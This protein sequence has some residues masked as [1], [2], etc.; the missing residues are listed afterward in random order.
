MEIHV[1]DSVESSQRGV[2]SPGPRDVRAETAAPRSSTCIAA[3]WPLR[4]CWD[5]LGIRMTNRIYRRHPDRPMAE[6]SSQSWRLRCAW[7][8]S[9]FPS[10]IHAS[11]SAG[12]GSLAEGAASGFQHRCFRYDSGRLS[13]I[14]AYF[15]CG[16]LLRSDRNCSARPFEMGRIPATCIY[17]IL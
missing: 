16:M 1:V 4:R 10:A 11:C 6:A 8:Q 15:S 3:D 5:L 9:G 7:L 13:N 12:P 17:G 2:L 14:F